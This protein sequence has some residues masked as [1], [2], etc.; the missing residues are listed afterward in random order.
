MQELFSGKRVLLASMHGKESAIGPV[1]EHRMGWKL[2]LATDLNTDQFGTF[3]GEIAR[4]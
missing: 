2:E 3:S 1:L 4:I